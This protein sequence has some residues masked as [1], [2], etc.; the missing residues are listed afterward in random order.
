MINLINQDQICNL[1][2]LPASIDKNPIYR[3][4]LE[5][6]NNPEI[7][8][9]ET[10]LYDFYQEIN[11]KSL[12]DLY[13][14]KAKNNILDQYQI[15]SIFLPWIHLSPVSHF[16]DPIF[17]KTQSIDL[18]ENQINK[19]R[20]LI[21]SI[22]QN[23]YTPEEYADRKHGHITG[24]FLERDDIKRFYVVSGNHRVAVLSAIA[25]EEAIK[26]IFEKI[27]FMKLRDKENNGAIL[28]GTLASVFKASQVHTWPSVRSGFLD[29]GTALQIFDRYITA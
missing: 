15:D 7:A 21:S 12:S 2:R 26:A 28:S 22:R 10:Y 6:I 14:L 5:I 29:E 11:F 9:K 3:T 17:L 4:C 16:S 20:R 23:G 1:G 27:S 13:S 8:S 24:Y 25:P 19:L 18:I